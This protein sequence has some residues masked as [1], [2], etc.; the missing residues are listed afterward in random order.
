MAFEVCK[1]MIAGN[2]EGNIT[3]F[4]SQCR[5]VEILTGGAGGIFGTLLT[6]LGITLIIG[7]IAAIY[8]YFAMAWMA[9]AK[10]LKYKRPWLA[11][12]PII[13]FFLIPILAKKHWTW[14]FIFLIPIVN[15]VFFIIW[16]WKIFELRKYPGWFSLSIL[17][18]QVGGLLYMIAVGLA[19][20]KKN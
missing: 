12:I 3:E 7:L 18:P 5:V 16:H 20:W 6:F 1:E 14:G 19:A 4:I 11:W 13:N 10:K 2:F 17:I 9:I 15:I 8:V